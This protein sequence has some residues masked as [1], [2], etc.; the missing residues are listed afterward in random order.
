MK[1]E[2]REFVLFRVFDKRWSEMGL[3]DDDLMELENAI[4]ENPT[5]GRVIQG[6]GGIRKMR[7]VLPNNKGKSGGSR[8]LYVDYVP[9]ETTVLLNAYPKSEKDNIT[10]KE[11]KLLKIEVEKFSKGLKK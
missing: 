4:M 11:K 7:F 5:T 9:F 3:T 8:V 10:D 2:K 6:T 1:R